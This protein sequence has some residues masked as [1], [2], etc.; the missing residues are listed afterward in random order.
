MRK[1]GSVGEGLVATGSNSKVDPAGYSMGMGAF[2]V[3]KGDGSKGSGPVEGEM[4]G[5]S[6]SGLAEKATSD[7]CGMPDVEKTK[8]RIVRG[9]LKLCRI[10]EHAEDLQEVSWIQ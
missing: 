6:K 4:N 3:G 7:G 10:A 1:V 2:H 5:K 8:R 9:T